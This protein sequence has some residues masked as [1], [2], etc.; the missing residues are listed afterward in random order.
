[1]VTFQG[2]D[3]PQ[4]LEKERSALSSSLTPRGIRHVNSTLKRD[5][6][7]VLLAPARDGN[8]DAFLPNYEEPFEDTVNR[9]ATAIIE[10]GDPLQVLYRAGIGSQADRFPS[11]V[12][13]WTVLNKEALPLRVTE[14]PTSKR[15]TTSFRV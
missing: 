2:L 6:L 11:W 4:E 13:D 3:Q 15:A 7:F 9:F 10:S 5:R 14:V 8:L 1:M 12:L